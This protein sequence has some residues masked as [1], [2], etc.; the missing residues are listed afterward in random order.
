MPVVVWLVAHST[1]NHFSL[2]NV[3]NVSYYTLLPFQNLK[4]WV[5]LMIT[6]QPLYISGLEDEEYCKDSAKGAL[7]LF[8]VTFLGSI[9]YLWFDSRNK[10]EWQHIPTSESHELLPRGMSFYNVR[11]DSEVELMG[12]GDDNDIDDGSSTDSGGFNLPPLS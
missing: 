4:W 2:S 1:Q 5:V 7:G 3:I 9:T 10:V 11:I 6:K 8:I 12:L